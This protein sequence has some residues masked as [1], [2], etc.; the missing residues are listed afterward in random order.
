MR[1]HSQSDCN[2]LNGEIDAV[3]LSTHGFQNGN[4]MIAETC[5]T[6]EDA[7]LSSGSWRITTVSGRVRRL[8]VAGD[9]ARFLEDDEI[10]MEDC[11]SHDSGDADSHPIRTHRCLSNLRCGLSNCILVLLVL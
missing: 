6:R 7:N 3:F 5:A 4:I 1:R 8:S 2:T 9:V 11:F 10:Q